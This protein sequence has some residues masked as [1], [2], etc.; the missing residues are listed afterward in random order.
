MGHLYVFFG[1]GPR[2]RFLDSERGHLLLFPHLQRISPH[3]LQRITFPTNLQLP[4]E[5][6]RGINWE[7]GI[8]I[9]TLLYIKQ[10]TNKDLLYSTGTSIFYNDLHGEKSR[11]SGYMY[12]WFTLLLLFSRSVVSDSLWPHEL[13]HARLPC[14]S[15]SLGSCSDSGPLSRWCHP[16][17]S[18]SVIPL[19][20]VFPS[21]S[22]SFL[23]R[24]L[25]TLR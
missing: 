13:Q 23:M 4:R 24:W 21:I 5:K 22:G 18:S 19:P 14:P 11:K 17:I 3:F 25:F 8:D 6:G 7:T 12:N 9:Y 1:K 20:S 2:N 10:I 15:P 16:T